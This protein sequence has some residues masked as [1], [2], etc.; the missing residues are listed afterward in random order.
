MQRKTILTFL[1]ATISLAPLTGTAPVQAAGTPCTFRFDIDVTP[2][3]SNSPSSGTFTTN[4]ETGTA[5]CKGKIN[6]RTITGPGTYGTEGRYGTDGPAT[7]T[8]GGKG[9]GT[10][11]M[12][13]PTSDGPQKF[14]APY[15]LT[16]GALENGVFSVTFKGD[17]W[18]GTARV[19]PTKGDCVSAPVTR[20]S[21]EGEGT[22]AG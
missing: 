16:S 2:G 1:L 12:T 19:R 6:G 13:L 15:T 14:T 20:M 21:A 17:R 3:L 7:C 11:S 22:M 18:S 10:T 5:D 4:G 9:E 8:S